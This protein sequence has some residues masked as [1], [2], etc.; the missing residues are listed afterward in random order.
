MH[1]TEIATIVLVVL[2]LAGLAFYYGRKIKRGE[3]LE[4]C[5]CAHAKKRKKKGPNPLV[6]EYHRCCCKK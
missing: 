2:F 4:T 6:E 5:A 1:W 3:P